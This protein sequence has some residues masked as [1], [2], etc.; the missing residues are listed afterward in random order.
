MQ[1]EEQETRT[2][3]R[4][5][6]VPVHCDDGR[7]RWL[8]WYEADERLVPDDAGTATEHWITVHRHGPAAV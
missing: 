7:W 2:V 8:A 4:F 6:L 5:A 3:R 1:P